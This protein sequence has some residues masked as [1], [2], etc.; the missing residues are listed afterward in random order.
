MRISA[1]W[2]GVD[3]LVKRLCEKRDKKIEKHLGLIAHDLLGKA[4]E[5]APKRRGVLAKGLRRRHPRKFEWTIEETG[6]GARF[7]RFVRSGTGPHPIYPRVKKALW[8]P[9]LSHPIPWVGPPYTRLHPGTPAIP[10][11]ERAVRYGLLDVDAR[12]AQMAADLAETVTR[13]VE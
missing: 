2:I 10:Y 6:E 3:E 5:L 7:G 11:H 8:W 4:R 12:V 9:G 1:L 13:K